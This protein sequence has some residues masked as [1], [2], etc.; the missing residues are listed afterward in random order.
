M[1]RTS[2]LCA[3]IAALLSAGAVHAQS[4][5][6]QHNHDHPAAAAASSATL[7]SAEGEIRKIDKESGKVTI[8]HGPLANL[9]M[10]GMTMAFKVQ[11]PAMLEKVKV[12]DKVNFAVDRINGAFTVT[13]LQIQD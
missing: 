9:K 1:I 6:H 4:H 5:E 3:A 10:P 13:Q 12:G 11:D 2:T 7:S 8:K